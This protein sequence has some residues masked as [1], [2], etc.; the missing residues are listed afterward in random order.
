M[1]ETMDFF[2][3]AGDLERS[4][5]DGSRGIGKGF[6]H[7]DDSDLDFFGT[8]TAHLAWR[9]GVRDYLDGAKALTCREAAS[10]RDCALGKWLSSEGLKKYGGFEDMQLMVCEHERPYAT[11]RKIIDLKRRGDETAAETHFSDVERLSANIVSL[12]KSV[13]RKA[14]A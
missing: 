3:V 2:S 13:E 12:L 1:G 6:G 14:S 10:D 5:E 8:R 4:I 9:Q 7:G 11:I